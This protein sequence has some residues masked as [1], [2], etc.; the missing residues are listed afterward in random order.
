MWITLT[1]CRRPKLTEAS[2]VTRLAVMAAVA[3]SAITLFG[4]T[5]TAP[6]L[7]RIDKNACPFECCQ[8]GNWKTTKNVQAFSG[9]ERNHRQKAFQI[10]KGE[11]VQA[12][13]G[14]NITYRPGQLRAL[15]SMADIHVKRG[16]TI[17][18]YMYRGE[19][20]IDSWANGR[21]LGDQQIETDVPCSEAKKA[22]DLPACLLNRGESEWWI[23]IK[24]SSGKQ[25]WVWGNQGFD[26]SD[27]CG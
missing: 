10:K 18:T 5:H 3:F 6:E 19:G 24:T 12:V 16:D 25:G 2:N 7:P 14:I 8:F 13:T 15:K 26:G 20:D 27:A 9:W 1:V 4:Q 23:L 22:P 17:L 11:K 21:W